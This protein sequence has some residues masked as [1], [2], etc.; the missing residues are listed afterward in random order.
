MV[1]Q[2]TMS[3]IGIAAA[4]LASAA[5]AQ[6]LATGADTDRFSHTAQISSGAD[7]SSIKLQRV[8]LVRI[9]ARSQSNAANSRCEEEQKFRDPGGSLYCPATIVKTPEQAYEVTFS[10]SGEPLASDEY[11][12]RF[13]KFSVYFRP[14]ELSESVRQAISH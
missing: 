2:K 10:Y 12:N 4:L 6:T 3:S 8:K 9:Y 13:F 11:G 5:T 7:V 1:Q 14:E